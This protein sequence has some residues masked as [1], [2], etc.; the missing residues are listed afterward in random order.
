MSILPGAEPLSAD[1]SRTGVLVCH[2][3]TGSP[4]SMRGIAEHCAQSGWTVRMPRLPGHG[5]TWQD[6]NQRTW[7][8]WHAEVAAAFLELRDRCDDVILVGL[9][10]G[11]S[12]MTLLAEEYGEQVAGL[13]LINPAYRMTDWRLKALPVLKHL[14]PSIA[15]IGDDIKKPGVREGAYPRTPLRALHS[16]TELWAKVTRDL[17]QVT[18]PVL[19]LHSRV[20][21]VVDP[22]NAELLLSRISSH[23]V[24]EVVLENSFHVATLD[25][26]ADLILNELTAFIAHVSDREDVSE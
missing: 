26:D 8:E 22:S 7:H 20:D 23:A 1:G 18:Q 15:A 10:M 13:V 21:H 25:H 11:G 19:L 24:R 3:F 16:A 5:T 4:S 17:P 14:T 6:L 9:S 2:G 12:L